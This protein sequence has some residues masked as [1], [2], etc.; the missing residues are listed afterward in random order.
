M[1]TSRKSVFAWHEPHLETSSPNKSD[2]MSQPRTT[3]L[4]IL[5]AGDKPT[6]DALDA[7]LFGVQSGLNEWADCE[8]PLMYCLYDRWDN[9]NS[10]Q[11]THYFPLQRNTLRFTREVLD[12]TTYPPQKYKRLKGSFGSKVTRALKDIRQR[13]PSKGPI[14]IILG[15]HGFS[16]LGFDTRNFLQ[17]LNWLSISQTTHDVDWQLPDPVQSLMHSFA[18][19]PTPAGFVSKPGSKKPDLT[20]DRATAMLRLLPKGRLQTLILHTCNMSGLETVSAMASIPHHIACE[21]DLF[22]HMRLAEWFSV[23]G[24]PHATDNDITVACFKS[25]A[26]K[27]RPRADGFF[28]SHRTRTIIAL[29]RKLDE[30][31][32]QL[33]QLASP[34]DANRVWFKIATARG[35]SNITANTV[36]V[37]KFCR[38][39]IQLNLDSTGLAQLIIDAIYD[40]QLLAPVNTSDEESP[41]IDK[42]TGGI[43]VYLPV[44]PN[45]I[46]TSRLP[47]TFQAAAPGWCRFVDNWIKQSP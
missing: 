22:S 39:L 36:D 21:A 28:S 7:L 25:L 16:G 45:P 20:L 38:S 14:R 11:R 12:P 23:L 31:G 19:D 24:D 29:L 9:V 46:P 10:R 35:Q 37:A 3:L 44:A 42:N 30:L 15:A 47:R 18:N 1:K 4:M 41:T 6:A 8:L 34:P 33:S 17:F 13:L 26:R 5:M 40:M 43:S 32:E 2:P 27:V